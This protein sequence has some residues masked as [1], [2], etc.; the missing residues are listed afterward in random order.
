MSKCRAP[1]LLRQ[2]ALGGYK[3]SYYHHRSKKRKSGSFLNFLNSKKSAQ[4]QDSPDGGSG[5][6]GK[7]ASLNYLLQK[8]DVYR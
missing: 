7:S 8:A 1:E 2:P 3:K 6:E 5:V 4:K